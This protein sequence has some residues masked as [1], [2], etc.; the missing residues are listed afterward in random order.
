MKKIYD[1]YFTLSESAVVAISAESEDEAQEIFDNMTR[2]DLL[3]YI[4]D[5]VCYGGFEITDIEEM[6]EDEDDI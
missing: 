1:V 3:G 5:S 2:D 4:H 6:D